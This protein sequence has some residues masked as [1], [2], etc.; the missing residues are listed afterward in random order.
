MGLPQKRTLIM[1]NK[2]R[3]WTIFSVLMCMA[4][5]GAWA[6]QVGDDVSD[7]A[8]PNSKVVAKIMD[9]KGQWV[10]LDFWASWCGPCRQSFP[11]MNELQEKKIIPGL[12]FLAINVDAN[13][14]DADR[15]L[16]QHPAVFALAFDA[17][18][19]SAKTMGLKVMPT[20][21]LIN[22]K[23]QVALIHAGFR[24]EERREIQDTIVKTMARYK[25]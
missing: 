17:S 13:K 9:L 4:L 21:Y 10:Y 18:G 6:A 19:V 20:S 12:S 25:P 3:C 7:L 14:I 1:M 8:L 23:G 11:W 24:V 22:P 5:S 16:S 15:F 2:L